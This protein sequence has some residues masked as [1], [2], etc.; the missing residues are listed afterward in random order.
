MRLKLFL[1][2]II[3]SLPFWWAINIGEQKL[4]DFLFSQEI[5]V[6]PSILTAQAKIAWFET[7][8]AMKPIKKSDAE[9]P[10]IQAIAGISVFLSS[11]KSP[12]GDLRMDSSNDFDEERKEKIL[13]SK[14]SDQKMSI[15][16]LTKLMTVLVVLK[17]YN[18][19]ENVKISEIAVNQSGDNGSLKVGESFSVKNLLYPLLIE[20]SNDA[21][22]ALAE[23]IGR[24]SFVDLMNLEAKRIG[25]KNTYFGN[26]TGLDPDED[27]LEMG[28]YSTLKD[29]VKLVKELIPKRI[30][31]SICSKPE[32]SFYSSDK[33]F[34]HKL[35]NT[36]ELLTIIPEII[37][38]KTGYT[39][40]SGGCLF[41][42]VQAPRNKG[43]IINFVLA[44]PN[45]FE[46]MQEL[47]TWIKE[48]Y[49]F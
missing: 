46:E 25:M 30:I 14:N 48:S 23:V 39:E 4:E 9:N 13:W 24:T 29:L 40:Q 6:N 20:S 34:H 45:R 10:K 44:S 42:L 3:I 18:L 22:Y 37:G 11:P 26:P 47:L 31:W 8:Q 43:H 5:A 41:L 35:V 7:I 27:P 2:A 28:N 16:S 49:Q 15:A 36:N 21:A 1:V 12:N 19:S 38:G 33:V 17:H 32:Y